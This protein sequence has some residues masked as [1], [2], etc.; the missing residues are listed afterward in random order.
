MP[1]NFSLMISWT[2]CS[3]PLRFLEFGAT[4]SVIL[5][6]LGGVGLGDFLRMPLPFGVAFFLLARVVGEVESPLASVFLVELRRDAEASSGESLEMV[7]LASLGRLRRGV[8]ALLL[9]FSLGAFRGCLNESPRRFWFAAL[10][11]TCGADGA[12]EDEDDEDEGGGSIICISSSLAPDSSSM[13]GS[14]KSSSSMM[15]SS[16]TSSSMM[17]SSASMTSSSSSSMISS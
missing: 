9:F 3:R 17:S 11:L 14:Q 13:M 16:T 12:G 4:L 10:L 8:L 1:S 5:G 7:P 6:I 2:C 15:S